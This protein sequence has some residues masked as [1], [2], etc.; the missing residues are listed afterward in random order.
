MPS[1][2]AG[3]NSKRDVEIEKLLKTIS[4]DTIAVVERKEVVQAIERLGELKARSAVDRLIELLDYH[5]NARGPWSRSPDR[6]EWLGK[7][8]YWNGYLYP[9]QGALIAIGESDEI[10]DKLL[11]SATRDDRSDVFRQNAI[12]ILLKWVGNEKSVRELIQ[13]KINAYKERVKN[14][15]KLDAV[16]KK[17]RDEDKGERP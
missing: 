17:M 14:L 6:P 15:E 1:E 4:K 11:D 3:E 7:N 2:A 16:V 13:K 8:E 5:V 10:V 12:D 9:A